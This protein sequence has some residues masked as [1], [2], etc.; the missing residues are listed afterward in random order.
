M[1]ARAIQSLVGHTFEDPQGKAQDPDLMDLPNT[2]AAF[3]RAHGVRVDRTVIPAPLIKEVVDLVDQRKVK[4][5]LNLSLHAGFFADAALQGTRQAKMISIDPMRY[6]P[7]PQYA[8]SFLGRRH[9]GR[10][11]VLAG[12]PVEALTAFTKMFGRCPVGLVLLDLRADAP[13]LGRVLKLLSGFLRPGT[14]IVV[15][16]LV[17]HRP[18]GACTL[19]EWTAAVEGGVVKETRHGHTDKV[20]DLWVIGATLTESDRQAIGA[21][22]PQSKAAKF[23][24]TSPVRGSARPQR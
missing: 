19:K 4:L 13:A 23:V 22:T 11:M 18:D 12:S 20:R 7:V 21:A 6:S 8:A 5:I 14:P 3:H 1:Q 2:L 17:P 16:N 15:N 9:R 24:Q 10:H